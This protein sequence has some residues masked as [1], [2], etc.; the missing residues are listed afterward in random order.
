[1]MKGR[2]ISGGRA[3]GV[4]ITYP[5]A[6]SF[7]GGVDGRTGELISRDG[8]IGGRV[9][10]FPKGKGSTVGSYVVYDLR[11]SGHAP[12][13]IVNRTAETI[14]TTGAVISSVPM[15]DGIDVSIVRDGDV[16]A[17]DG[18][19]GTVEIKGVEE[20]HVATA[21]VAVDGKVLL[22]RRP[23]GARSFP[24]GWSLVSGGVEGD[25]TPLEAARREV[26]EETGIAVG[27]PDGSLPEFR[28]REGGTVWVVHPVLFRLEEAEVALNGENAAYEWLPAAE[29]AAREG[30]VDGV[31]DVI[32]G[33][34]K[35]LRGPR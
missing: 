28:I 17:V 31:G 5:E 4:A 21:M 2:A 27:M 1:M 11:V 18:D 3:E 16:L 23:E 33:F 30:L 9:F 14:V 12:A 29:A 8:N 26:R 32:E 15:V 35:L 25:E 6:F 19:A 24:G 22:L 13:A 34:A 10:L 7:L 20:R